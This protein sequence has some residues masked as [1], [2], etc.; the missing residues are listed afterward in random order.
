MVLLN[1]VIS[2][3]YNKMK[4]IILKKSNESIIKILED[5]FY[6]KKDKD[7]YIKYVLNNMNQ[8]L[9]KI[10]E[11]DHNIY[12]FMNN[13]YCIHK[14]KRG[15]LD[16]HICG[17][18]IE[19]NSNAWLCSR[20]DRSYN[21]KPR[22]YSV[23]NPRCNHIRNNGERCKHKSL[24]YNTVCYIHT[25]YYSDNMKNDKNNKMNS[26]KK[27]KKL[28]LLYNKNKN[29]YKNKNRNIINMLNNNEKYR[30]K[31]SVYLYNK[32]MKKKEFHHIN[33]CHG[34]T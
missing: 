6:N 27:L 8:D 24:A 3:D 10:L 19:I 30:N 33:N 12:L 21:A 2:V 14:Y 11:F 1:E 20:H 16:G 31:I 25:K 29:R 7:N 26:I 28:R 4:N 32:K 13:K 9:K 18:K 23:K 5:L 15:R 34:I 17:A 22:E